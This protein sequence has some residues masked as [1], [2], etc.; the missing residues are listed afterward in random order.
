M[1][2][3]NHVQLYL[4][5]LPAPTHLG[6]QQRWP[7]L[8]QSFSY[9]FPRPSKRRAKLLQPATGKNLRL[10]FIILLFYVK[11]GSMGGNMSHRKQA[12]VS[13]MTSSLHKAEEAVRTLST[14]GDGL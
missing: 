2:V 12:P 13:E 1:T 4:S 10:L 11:F 3:H 7:W 6:P 14:G 5:S 8:R 9:G